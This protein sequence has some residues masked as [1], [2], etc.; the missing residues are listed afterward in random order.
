MEWNGINWSV[1]HYI[2]AFMP[3]GIYFSSFLCVCSSVRMY[4]CILVRSFFRYDNEKD[5]KVLR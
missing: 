1:S 2:P 4:V 5:V 3:R